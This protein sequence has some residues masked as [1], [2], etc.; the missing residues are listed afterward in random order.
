MG[1]E[2]ILVVALVAAA[3]A[4]I[5]QFART[6]WIPELRER[7]RRAEVLARGRTK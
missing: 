4:M 5:I 3:V 6:S 1:N 2:W 7:R